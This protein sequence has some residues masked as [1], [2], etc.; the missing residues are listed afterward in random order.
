MKKFA[1][2]SAAVL[3]ILA[4]S[5][6]EKAINDLFGVSTFTEDT[7]IFNEATGKTDVVNTSIEASV[8][9]KIHLYLADGFTGQTGNFFRAV[10]SSDNMNVAT[11][12]PRNGNETY[13]TVS[14]YGQAVIAVSD[15]EGNV[16]TVRIIS[17]L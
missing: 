11:V 14:N 3:V 12:S 8:N 16:L 4:L 9:T 1:F 13:V 10:W 5:S 15:I 6:C 7:V 17:K 2:L